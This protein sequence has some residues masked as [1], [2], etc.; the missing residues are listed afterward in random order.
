[1]NPLLVKSVIAVAIV[2]VAAVCA[3]AAEPTTAEKDNLSVAQALNVSGG[4]SQLSSYETTDKEGKPSKAYFQF[5]ADVTMLMAINIDLGRNL[6]TR[7]ERA[8]QDLRMRLSGGSGTVP[9]EKMGEFNQEIAALADA[10]SR[11][12]FLHI[13]L[14][15]LCLKKDGDCKVENA[16][17]PNTLSLILPIV[18][19]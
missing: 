4:L 9:P 12:G 17:P 15:D 6:Q 14:K 8:V 1:M 5:N 2:F 13:K 3:I 7:F 19:R 18:D 10:P 16:I 11:V